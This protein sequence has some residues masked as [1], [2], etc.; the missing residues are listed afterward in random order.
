MITDS[1]VTDSVLVW[2][3]QVSKDSSN[4]SLCS[5]RCRMIEELPAQSGRTKIGAREKNQIRWLALIFA[6]PDF[7]RSRPPTENLICRIH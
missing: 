4:I 7:T 3:F 6:P 5:K 2:P 1:S